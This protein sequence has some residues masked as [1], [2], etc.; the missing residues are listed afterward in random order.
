METLQKKIAL[1]FDLFDK[2]DLPN[3]EQ[4]FSECLDEI[5]DNCLSLFKETLFGMG[6]VKA[7]MG[8]F[9]E[10]R[11]IYK[12]LIEMTTYNGEVTEKTRYVHQLGMVER[13]AMNLEAAMQIFEDEYNLL[14]KHQLNND[15]NKSANLYER[16]YIYF[17]QNQNSIALHFMELSLKHA[18]LSGD[19]VC[20]A[21]SCRG[22]GQIYKAIGKRQMEVMY[23]DKSLL[24]FQEANDEIGVK[25]VQDLMS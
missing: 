23:F 12:Q 3:A 21:C 6:Y 7:H 19:K 22:L 5:S 15:L 8:K 10:A 2:G 14:E 24:A 11:S 9:E 17:L 20:I 16:G 18:E 25:E 13:M 1:A 4:L